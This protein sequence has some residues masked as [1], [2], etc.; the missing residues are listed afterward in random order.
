MIEAILS[1]AIGDYPNNK[2]S[3]RVRKDKQVMIESKLPASLLTN[4]RALF[5]KYIKRKVVPFMT[6]EKELTFKVYPAIPELL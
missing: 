5:T 4:N 2:M 1:Y 6:N 3:L